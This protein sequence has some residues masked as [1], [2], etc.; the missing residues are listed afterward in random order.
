[1]SPTGDSLWR[2]PPGRVFQLGSRDA[3]EPRLRI[4]EH[5]G[6]A[7][8]DDPPSARPPAEQVTLPHLD[9]RGAMLPGQH[10]G[11]FEGR[12][13][14][15]DRAPGALRPGG[16]CLVGWEAAARMGVV[17]APQQARRSGSAARACMVR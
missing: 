13:R 1:M 11:P 9:P 2:L 7:G 15:R 4:L 10:A 6:V 8:A 17:E 16:D 5:V 14:F 3:D 12:E